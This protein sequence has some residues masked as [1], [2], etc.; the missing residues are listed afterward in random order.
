MNST[1]KYDIMKA[2]AGKGLSKMTNTRNLSNYAEDLVYQFGTYDGDCYTLSLSDVPDEEQ[3][4]LAGLY[5]DANGRD[6]V[7]CVNGNDFSIDN[8]YISA[9]LL[10]LKDNS[11]QNRENFAEVTRKNIIIYYEQSLQSI[12]D[13]AC[14]DFQNNINN[15]NGFYAHVDM[16]HGDV[17]CSKY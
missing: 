14:N 13:E 11:Q 4:E 15:E 9:L 2:H 12:I 7:E 3:N 8:N 17:I 5:I 6:V 16:D 10:M 1:H